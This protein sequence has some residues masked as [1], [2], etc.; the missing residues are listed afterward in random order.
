[1]PRSGLLKSRAQDWWSQLLLPGRAVWPK[2]SQAGI[3]SAGKVEAGNL[4]RTSIAARSQGLQSSTPSLV[5]V[6]RGRGKNW[7]EHL[8][9]PN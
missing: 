3:R 2:A 6:G 7:L 5:G 1:M 9:H 8:P 4:P